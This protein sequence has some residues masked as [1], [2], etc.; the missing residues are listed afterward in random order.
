MSQYVNNMNVAIGEMVFVEFGCITNNNN[1]S[2]IKLAMT[3]DHLKKVH[4]TMGA[5][6]SDVENKLEQKKKAN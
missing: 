3:Y 6:I 2:T 1:V 4:E 5:I